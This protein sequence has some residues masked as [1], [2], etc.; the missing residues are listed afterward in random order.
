[1]SF[2]VVNVEYEGSKIWV[3][4]HPGREEGHEGQ[5]E[6]HQQRPVRSEPA[7]LRDPGLQH[8]R[9]RHA[10]R[11]EADRVHG[12]QGGHLPDHLPAP[13][14]ARGRASWSS[15]P[16]SDPFVDSPRG[17]GGKARARRP[18]PCG[19]VASRSCSSPSPRHRRRRTARRS[20]R[21]QGRHLQER[22][23]ARVRV[24]RDPA[25]ASGPSP[26]CPTPSA[27]EVST[28]PVATQR[29][30]VHHASRSR[31]REVEAE[32]RRLRLRRPRRAAGGCARSAT[33][34]RDSSP[35]F[36]GA[37]HARRR[38]RS[39]TLQV[40][41]RRSARRASTP[42]CTTSRATTRRPLVTRKPS[43]RPATGERAFWACCTTTGRLLPTR[44]S[45]SRPRSTAL[46][47]AAKRDKKDGWSRFLIAMMHLYRFGQASR[48]LSRDVS[49]TATAEIAA[50][51]DAFEQAVPLLW[52]GNEG[53]LAR[54]RLRRRGHLRAGRREQ[55]RRVPGAGD[56]RPRRG[57]PG[58]SVLQRLR[59]H[60]GRAGGAARS[61]RA[62]RRSSRG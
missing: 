56:R 51:H 26:A 33:G 48:A 9:G 27:V 44:R 61:I 38:D 32:G 54:P 60:P 7:R 3:P 11:A 49:D 37:L 52:D 47:K 25:L 6:A 13:P 8:R 17:P 21:R 46:A 62:S 1:M 4:E 28:Y 36:G 53:R 30:A 43:R 5:A 45:S 39:A 34:A 29:V 35:R 31:L 57:V 2:T 12:R 15:C 40:V 50:A 20:V 22:R 59:L 10:R 16:E 55:R 24:G 18:P 42:A 23:V 58:Q 14:G 19:R 41:A